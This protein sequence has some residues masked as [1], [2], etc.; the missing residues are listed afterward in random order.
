MDYEPLGHVRLYVNTRD[1]NN[2]DTVIDN[3][4]DPLPTMIFNHRRC[5]TAAQTATVDQQPVATLCAAATSV[6]HM[7][8]S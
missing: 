8:S 1:E 4:W 3:I 6:M 5:L 2:M 7:W